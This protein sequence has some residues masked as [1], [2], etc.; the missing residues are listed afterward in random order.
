MTKSQSS[1]ISGSSSHHIESIHKK[2]KQEVL[3]EYLKR[4]A[5]LS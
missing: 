1:F 2:D 5:K 3:S 4:I